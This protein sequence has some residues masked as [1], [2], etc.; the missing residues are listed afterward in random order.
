MDKMSGPARLRVLVDAELTRR[1][2]RH[3]PHCDGCHDDPDARHAAEIEVALNLLAERDAATEKL[4]RRL[5][6]DFEPLSWGDVGWSAD[7]PDVVTLSL[8]AKDGSERRANIPVT[9]VQTIVMTAKLGE[10]ESE[11]R[12]AWKRQRL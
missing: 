6:A 12:A 10:R 2:A 7:R 1:H 4:T 9:K 5:E 3:A 11:R 8:R